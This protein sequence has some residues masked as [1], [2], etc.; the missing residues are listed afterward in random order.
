MS[1]MIDLLRFMVKNNASDLHLC[2][3]RK[4]HMRIQGELIESNIDTVKPG[5]VKELIYSILDKEQIRHLEQHK[6][7]DMAYM[8]PD[9]C[10][11][12]INVYIQRGTHGAVVRAIP[13]DISSFEQLGIPIEIKEFIDKLSGLILV[14]GPHR[15]GKTTTL[16]AII[17]YINATRKAHIITIEDPIEYVHRSKKSVINQREIGR[18][19]FS[20][21]Q[22]IHYVLRQD[23][24]VCLIGELRD[25]E[26][27]LSSLFMAEAGKLVLSTLHS[28]SASKAVAR[29]IDMFPPDYQQQ[30]RIQLAITLR[31]IISQQLIPRRDQKGLVLATELMKKTQSMENLIRNFYAINQLSSAIQTGREQGM[32]NMDQCLFELYKSGRISKYELCKRAEDPVLIEDWLRERQQQKLE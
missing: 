24:D 15:C 3:G 22:A 28:T 5:Y 10:R 18:D 16:A 26:S 13:F 31:A 4:P 11:F 19:T 17:D 7:L 21:K 9:L 1:E 29:I 12:R 27:V 6:E 25:T 14:T 20:Y 32:W 8:M 30:I 2:A 23:A